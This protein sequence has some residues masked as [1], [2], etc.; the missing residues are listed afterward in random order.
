[1]L[2]GFSGIAF[3]KFALFSYSSALFWTAAFFMIGTFF[4][5]KVLHLLAALD[6]KLVALLHK[7]QS[8]SQLCPYYCFY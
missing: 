4:G 5:D 3:K 1:V 7:S 2:I 6:L 8:L